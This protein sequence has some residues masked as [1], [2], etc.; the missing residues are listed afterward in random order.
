[1][2]AGRPVGSHFQP[3][4]DASAVL[5][6]AGGAVSSE[7]KASGTGSPS[8]EAENDVLCAQVLGKL[9]SQAEAC[10]EQLEEAMQ[11][12]L[13]NPDGSVLD[14]AARLESML[15]MMGQQLS[16][17]EWASA[18]IAV[19]QA[20]SSSLENHQ[21]KTSLLTL[22]EL[23]RRLDAFE[24]S[25]EVIAQDHVASTKQSSS[26]ET[27][28]PPARAFPVAAPSA[29]RGTAPRRRGL[30]VD[31]IRAQAATQAAKRQGKSGLAPIHPSAEA[32]LGTTFEMED[33]HPPVARASSRASSCSSAPPSR[34]R[35]SS[36]TREA[37]RGREHSRSRETSHGV[38]AP[39]CAAA[40]GRRS[41]SQSVD[42]QHGAAER[43]ESID[44]LG[45][46]T[47][48]R[49][50]R[51]GSRQSEKPRMSMTNRSLDPQE[52]KAQME[53]ERQQFIQGK[54]LESRI[55]VLSAGRPV[56]QAA[57]KDAL[58]ASQSLGVEWLEVPSLE[59]LRQ[60]VQ[61]ERK[62][63]IERQLAAEGGACG[64]YVAQGQ[65]QHAVPEKVA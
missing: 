47:G 53:A 32:S 49:Q 62:A 63:F 20:E 6:Q 56:L 5:S 30:A 35:T 59:E 1:M 39:A 51:T 65:L 52:L 28:V 14:V 18:G 42:K 23:Q 61:H 29:P 12:C 24:A 21:E 31:T 2:Q 43:S 50:S 4:R 26:Q 22:L 36:Q 7:S 57:P 64:G 37:S 46:R 55:P 11:H 16:V 27:P 41:R 45:S 58:N 10:R 25:I 48:S 34:G 19:E 44:R 38:L 15:T 33:V 60:Q 54:L 40:S 13:A 3:S 8:L 9:R 17:L